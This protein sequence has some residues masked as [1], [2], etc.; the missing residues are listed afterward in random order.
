MKGPAV[1]FHLNLSDES[2]VVSYRQTDGLAD[3]TK[4]EVTLRIRVTT[5]PLAVNYSNMKWKERHFM[6]TLK[7][8]RIMFLVFKRYRSVLC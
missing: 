2:Q 7:C 1:S 8:H 6:C 3:A 4:V 5:A